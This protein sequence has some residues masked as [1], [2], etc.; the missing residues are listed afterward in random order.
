MG[1]TIKDIARIAGVSIGTVSNY[2]NGKQ[3]VQAD[4]AERIRKAIE[5]TS[6][7][8]NYLA[9]NLRTR[10]SSNIGVLLPD[11]ENPYY[12]KIFEGIE[13][14]IRE[15]TNTINLSL[16]RNSAEYE[17]DCIENLLRKQISGLILIPSMID[18]WEFY[19]KSFTSC[20]KPLILLDRR[21]NNIESGYISFNYE[22]TFYRL[23]DALLEAGKKNIVLITESNEYSCEAE[24]IEGFKSAHRGRKIPHRENNI[25]SDVYNKEEAF[26]TVVNLFVGEVPDAIMTTSENKALGITEGLLFLGYRKDQIPVVSLG[27]DC[28]NEKTHTISTISTRRPAFEMGA[29][30]AGNL[31]ELIQYPINDNKQLILKDRVEHLHSGLAEKC[32]VPAA[33]EK[34]PERQ[35]KIKVLMLETPQTYALMSMLRNF[36]TA[37]GIDAEIEIVEHRHLYKRIQEEQSPDSGSDHADVFMFDIPWLQTLVQSK[38]IAGI[39]DC[40]MTTELDDSMFFPNTTD[41][42]CR[43]DEEVYG[44][45]FMHALQ[46]LYYRKDIF[47]N[48]DV[49]SLYKKKYRSPLGLPRTWKEFNTVAKF[50]TRDT[51]VIPYG[52]SIPGA[53]PECLSPEIFLRFFSHKNDIFGSNNK[54][55]FDNPKTLKVYTQ[56]MQLLQHAKPDWRQANDED[57][58]KDFLNKETAMLISYPSYLNKILLQDDFPLSEKSIGFSPTPKNTPVLGGW[59]MGISPKTAMKKESCDFIKW[60]CTDDISNYFSLL[61]GFSAVEKTYM[62]DELVKIFPW[63]SSYHASHRKAKPI[64]PPK[65]PEG[66]VIPQRSIDEILYTWFCRMG[67]K[68]VSI[69]E[70]IRHTQTGLEK[71]FET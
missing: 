21:I 11:F 4:T 69:P 67:D 62:N 5:E 37:Y 32:A 36:Q 22:E 28:W 15:S 65:N 6:Y 1:V 44:L 12:V 14:V 18:D 39:S 8:P 29:T 53:Y 20:N 23:T 31:M 64:L 50:F 48:P 54:V 60:A 16:T 40:I 26:R 10:E 51:D 59:G 43:I 13:S 45:P 7:E 61:G 19:Y 2:I 66:T 3:T 42:F 33:A 34:M 17:K 55:R 30:A 9:K 58:V 35:K 52:V 70:A 49:R 41:F 25:I 47:E 24:C 63:F 68:E 56:F 46:I 57:V 38:L 27:E 71:L